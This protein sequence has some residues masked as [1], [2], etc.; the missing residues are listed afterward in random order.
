MDIA[1]IRCTGKVSGKA[2]ILG[3]CER[4]DRRDGANS[5]Q[6]FNEL[7]GGADRVDGESADNR[8]LPGVFRREIGCRCTGF[9]RGEK[10]R[11]HTVYRANFTAQ[12]QLAEKKGIGCR[13]LGQLSGG[14]EDG[15]EDRQIIER[16]VFAQLC[17]GKVNGDPANRIVHTAVADGRADPLSGFGGG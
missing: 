14:A 15:S 10:H 8:C 5:I 4:D 13:L 2:D 11:K 17:R 3:E 1:E 12:G 7:A 6:M 16:A 9:L